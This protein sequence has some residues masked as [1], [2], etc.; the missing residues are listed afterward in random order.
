MTPLETSTVL[1]TGIT[2]AASLALAVAGHVHAEGEQ[3]VSPSPLRTC[4]RRDP[5]RAR[6]VPREGETGRMS[7]GC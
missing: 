5:A 1:V 3:L 2:N 6:R 7:F 4:H